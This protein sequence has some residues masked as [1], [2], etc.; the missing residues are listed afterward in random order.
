MLASKRKT[1][2]LSSARGTPDEAINTID[3]TPRD[4]DA[5][6]SEPDEATPNRISVAD[7]VSVLGVRE[8]LA[9][10]L[11]GGVDVAKNTRRAYLFDTASSASRSPAVS[12]G[13]A[14][15]SDPALMHAKYERWLP[16]DRYSL[17]QVPCMLVD[18]DS[19][20]YHF[21]FYS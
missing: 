6:L 13:T 18:G 10:I 8:H 7:V 14:T 2:D 1:R 21:N 16:F 11:L 4:G 9:K 5:N 12:S 3:D 19:R 20:T 15:L 17:D